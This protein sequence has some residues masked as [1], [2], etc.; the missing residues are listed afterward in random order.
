MSYAEPYLQCVREVHEMMGL[1]SDSSDSWG[2]KE[3]ARKAPRYKEV[4]VGKAGRKAGFWKR[5][6]LCC[7]GD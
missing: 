2:S 4:E 7:V 5:L 3:R 6:F 1:Y